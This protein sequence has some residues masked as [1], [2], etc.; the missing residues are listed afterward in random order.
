MGVH[1]HLSTVHAAS[2]TVLWA[3]PKPATGLQTVGGKSGKHACIHLQ[4]TSMACIH[5]AVRGYSHNG[6]NDLTAFQLL[7]HDLR[8][9]YSTCEAVGLT[10]MWVAG[11][12]RACRH[13]YLK[14]YL[15]EGISLSALR[16]AKG[17]GNGQG[18]A[19]VLDSWFSLHQHA[20]RRHKHLVPS[21]AAREGYRDRSVR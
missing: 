7:M 15:N 19:M 14:Y 2:T 18:K 4:V 21:Q 11:G 16:K 3:S 6:T 5:Y 17:D 10:R 12:K 8:Q 20:S 9:A 13:G 1:R